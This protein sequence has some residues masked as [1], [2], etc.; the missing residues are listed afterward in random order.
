MSLFTS[1][2]TWL[3]SILSNLNDFRSLE[4]VNRASETQLQV[5]EN[6]YQINWRLNMLTL[7]FQLCLFQLFA[8]HRANTS[9][10]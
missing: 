8:D 3:T 2:S 5:G 6:S 7:L 4:V 10:T 9:F 1:I